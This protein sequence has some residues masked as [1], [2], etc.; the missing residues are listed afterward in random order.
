MSNSFIAPLAIH[1]SNTSNLGIALCQGTTDENNKIISFCCIQFNDTFIKLLGL[2]EENILN[3]PFSYPA[4]D[5]ISF[6][7]QDDGFKKPL[8]KRNGEHIKVDFI[9]GN[10]ANDNFII[11]LE[12]V[13]HYIEDY[14]IE[15]A[16]EVKNQL[17][18]LSINNN[19]PMVIFDMKTQINFNKA[20]VELFGYSN[21]EEL[22]AVPY[23]KLSPEFQ[24]NGKHSHE[25]MSSYIQE[26]K[27]SGFIQFEWTHIKKDGTLIPVQI[28]YNFM[29]IN[30]MP[31][32]SAILKDLTEI[33]R[34]E[35]A[36]K[37]EHERLLNEM[38]TPIIPILKDTILLPL[39]GTI[40]EKRADIAVKV[41]LTA[42]SDMQSR[43]IIID[44]SGVNISSIEVSVVNLIKLIASAHLMG[45]TTI[46]C[47]VSPELAQSIIELDLD[48]SSLIS[49][50]NLEEALKIAIKKSYN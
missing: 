11:Q 17:I 9:K 7:N 8:L 45:C 24:P 18:N 46:L 47:G 41:A 14:K 39:I 4:Y 42:I 35:A 13:T 15:M 31:I 44:V 32:I 10:S 43:V 40:T 1:L 3:Q 5:F 23:N 36:N 38:S 49:T 26:A 50:N 37:L 2:E 21:A 48:L 19:I 33:K 16:Y 29:V 34:L 20:Y 30:N 28:S 12:I 25:L 6:I 27:Q 22:L